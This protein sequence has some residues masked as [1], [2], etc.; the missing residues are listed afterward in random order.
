MPRTNRNSTN[1]ISI[2]TKIIAIEREKQ[3][4]SIPLIRELRGKFNY[5][6]YSCVD[7]SYTI[8]QDK[9]YFNEV[10]KIFQIILTNNELYYYICNV[11]FFEM[12]VGF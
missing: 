1:I 7:F 2:F 10:R 3:I 12:Y 8:I 9:T 11:W 4:F 5:I 6:K